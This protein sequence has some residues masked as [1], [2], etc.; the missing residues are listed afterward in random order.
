MSQ[1]R[2]IAIDIDDTIA[3]TT[4]AIRLWGNAL[5][6]V[7]MTKDDYAI[8]GEYWGYYERV[9]EQKD[10]NSILKFDDAEAAIIADEIKV[11]LLAGASFAI[12]ELEKKFTII[13]ITSRNPLLEPITRRWL[14]EHFSGLDIQLYFA[15]NPKEGSSTK[16]TKGQLCK[17]LGAFLHID[18]NVDHCQSVLDE[19][20]EAVL[21]G[22]YGWQPSL[23]DG[24]VRCVDWPAV[25]EYVG[26]R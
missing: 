6:G 22:N 9:W 24:A 8:E 19:G 2:I 21:Y 10:L 3:G 23:P 13:L 15:N 4:D 5:S 1:K 16:K 25:L 20:L 26:G 18:D 17:E 11:P 7:E 12:H 14:D